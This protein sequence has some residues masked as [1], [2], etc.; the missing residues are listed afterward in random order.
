M[1]EVK[2]G[3]KSSLLSRMGD[4][5]RQEDCVSVRRSGRRMGKGNTVKPV[6]QGKTEH[7]CQHS[8]ATLVKAKD[9]SCNIKLSLERGGGMFAC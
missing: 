1:G 4:C 2:V 7:S 3:S 9:K 5:E 8:K 6:V